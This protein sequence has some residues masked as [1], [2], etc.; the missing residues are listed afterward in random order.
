MKKHLICEVLK[1]SIAEELEIEAGDRLV[2]INDREI[3]DY[4]DYEFFVRDSYLEMLIEKPDGEEWLLE[5]DKD[6]EEEMGLVFENDMMDGYRSCANKCIFCFIDQM[7]PGMRESLYFKDDDSRL[8]FLHGNYVTLTNMSDNDIDRIIRYRMSPIYI[9]FQTTN[10]ELRCKMLGNRFAGESL[11]KA[12]RLYEAGIEMNG[13][14]VL[15]KGVNDGRELERTISDLSAYAPLLRSVSVVPVGLTKYREKLF[16][17]EPFEKEDA[18]C[19]IAL[20][21]KWQQKIFGEYGYHFIHA[22]DEFYLLAGKELPKEERYDGYLQYENGVGMLRSFMDDFDRAFDA[23]SERIGSDPAL[24]AVK[25]KVTIATGRLAWPVINDSAMKLPALMPGLDISVVPIRNDFFGELITVTGLLTGQDIVAQLKG[26]KLGEALL[27]SEGLARD[28]EPVLL[29]DM[30][31]G[32][33]EKSLQVHIDIV[34]SN[35][36]DFIEKIVGEVIYE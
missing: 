6:P 31:I 32:D 5:I 29:D 4:F 11:K 30:S 18:L 17:L 26:K 21:E 13:Q 2:K 9:S 8:S 3:L 14:I 7:P 12:D 20:I 34:K 24:K 10:P 28:S 35:G 23:L 22:S 27:L 1:D 15:C 19:V 33:M 36:M 16:K 25:R